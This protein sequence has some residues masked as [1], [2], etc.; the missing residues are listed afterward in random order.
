MCGLQFYYKNIAKVGK[1]PSSEAMNLGKYFEYKCTG[2]YDPR[3]GIPEPKTT[4]KGLSKDYEVADKNAI[5][6]VKMLNEYG[7]DMV[8]AGTMLE[9]PTM[10]GLLDLHG[11]YKKGSKYGKQGQDVIIDIKN[12][13]Q[14]D[15]EYDDYGWG[16][17]NI[18]SK[19]VLLV[20]SVQYIILWYEL[21]GKIAEFQFWIFNSKKE[22]D[23]KVFRVNLD[24]TRI[25]QHAE[26]I[27]KSINF[28]EASKEKVKSGVPPEKMFAPK[29]TMSGCA[30]CGMK[31][32]CKFRAVVPTIRDI[33]Y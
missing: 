8:A 27:E 23:A 12:S 26:M 29:P 10:R 11:K 21:T 28:I 2:Y 16:D 24:K 17:K 32:E 1:W 3:D 15:N 5:L 30:E 25:I 19:D 33:Y 9:T 20:Q 7:I 18:E 22:N 13:G 4:S 31:D 6:F 14:I